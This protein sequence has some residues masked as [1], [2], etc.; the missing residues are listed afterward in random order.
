[1]RWGRKKEATK[2]DGDGQSRNKFSKKKSGAGF[3]FKKR[4]VNAY[5]AHHQWAQLKGVGGSS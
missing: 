1:M 2:L 3:F 4:L 5:K